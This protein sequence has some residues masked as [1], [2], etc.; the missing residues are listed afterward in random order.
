MND[1]NPAL[2]FLLYGALVLL[3]FGLCWI[4]KPDPVIVYEWK[5]TP[6][7]YPFF[8]LT[9]NVKVVHFPDHIKLPTKDDGKGGKKKPGDLG[10]GELGPAALYFDIDKKHIIRN[11]AGSD[12]LGINVPVCLEIIGRHG[13]IK[14]M[15]GFAE[16]AS[17]RPGGH[18]PKKT[19][20]QFDDFK[21]GKQFV[22]DLLIVEPGV[23][24]STETLCGC[25]ETH[26]PYMI[27]YEGRFD[28][29]YSGHLV[30]TAVIVNGFAPSPGNDRFEI[31]DPNWPRDRIA[32]PAVKLSAA[33]RWIACLVPVVKADAPCP[34]GDSCTCNPC[35]CHAAK[36][37]TLQSGGEINSVLRAIMDFAFASYE[38]ID[39]DRFK[40][41]WSGQK[42]WVVPGTD[43]NCVFTSIAWGQDDSPTGIITQRGGP[44]SP[45]LFGIESLVS[46]LREFKEAIFGTDKQAG[47]KKDIA[48]GLAEWSGTFKSAAWWTAGI[49]GSWMAW[50]GISSHRT[51]DALQRLA[52]KA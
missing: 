11:M 20:N 30:N 51:A 1:K 8:E 12:G 47:L 42:G 35:H 29:H 7:K 33:C 37:T 52:S 4:T 22:V 26:G 25:L 43:S 3:G 14:E 16:W 9:A 39:T 21:I 10:A 5:A 48:T 23:P 2:K 49:V 15:E 24:F 50:M 38:W 34:C 36:A 27:A 32:V 6:L 41:S 40:M 19:I 44:K 31:I 17:K 46:I 13:G 28:D 45:E 18:Y